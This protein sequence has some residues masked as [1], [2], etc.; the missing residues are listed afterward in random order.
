MPNAGLV[1][2]AQD[3]SSPTQRNELRTW[4]PED[5]L[6]RQEGQAPPGGFVSDLVHNI[7]QRV[8]VSAIVLYWDKNNSIHHHKQQCDTRYV[9]SP[10]AGH[11]TPPCGYKYFVRVLKL[12]LPVSV[13]AVKKKKKKLKY[14][15]SVKEKK[16]QLYF[17]VVIA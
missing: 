7:S 8:D 15:N 2:C 9:L 12:I 10:T 1:R 14:T 11:A 13:N 17:V 3:L 5:E 6:V 16:K 4:F